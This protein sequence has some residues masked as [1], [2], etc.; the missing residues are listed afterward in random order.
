MRN[1]KKALSLI[2]YLYYRGIIKNIQSFP[3]IVFFF[4]EIL[5]KLTDLRSF[6]AILVDFCSI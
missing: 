2:S 3:E 4:L 1:I 6:L 5:T